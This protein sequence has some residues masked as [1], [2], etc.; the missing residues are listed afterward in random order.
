[1]SLPDSYRPDHLDIGT[2]ERFVCVM[3]GGGGGHAARCLRNQ[4]ENY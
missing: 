3:G 4:L 1:M 2:A